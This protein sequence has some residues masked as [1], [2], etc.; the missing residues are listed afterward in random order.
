MWNLERDRMQCLSSKR[1]DCF[2]QPF[3][4]DPSPLGA[5]VD[6]IADDGVADRFEVDADLV[7]TACV[8]RASQHRGVAKRLDQLVAE[9]ARLFK[10]ACGLP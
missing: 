2:L 7:C 4:G 8:Q 9:L 3:V 6:R 10:H 5:G 1:R